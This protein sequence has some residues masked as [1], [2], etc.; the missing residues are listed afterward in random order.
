MPKACAISV[1]LDKHLSSEN[2]FKV[3]L[4]LPCHNVPVILD[5]LPLWDQQTL[6]VFKCR[7]KKEIDLFQTFVDQR[8]E[9]DINLQHQVLFEP[10]LLSTVYTVL[11]T[12]TKFPCYINILFFSGVQVCK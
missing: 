8:L 12:S 9:E 3:Y 1:V 4:T 7:E 6:G 10:N 2:V 5:Q 11:P